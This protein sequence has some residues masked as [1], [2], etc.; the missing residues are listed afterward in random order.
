MKKIYNFLTI[1]FLLVF[2]VSCEKDIANDVFLNGVAPILNI[3]AASSDS[4]ALNYQNETDEAAYISWTNPNYIFASGPN[5]QD[6]VYKLEIDSFGKNFSGQFKKTV[7]F[8]NDL[9]VAYNVF[10]FNA[11]L[12]DLKLKI[13]TDGKISMRLISSING[14]SFTELT[15]AQK[16]FKVRP[17]APPPKVNPP[18]SGNLWV[19][20]DAFA[21]SW[22]N[23]LASPYDVSQKFTKISDTRYELLVSFAGGG[24]YKIIQEQ[25]VWGTQFHKVAGNFGNGTF[26]Q[27]DADPA[28][29]GAPAAGLYKIILDFQEGTYTVLAAN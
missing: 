24:G 20:G 3:E 28:F 13:N 21:S 4:I 26:E 1:L 10:Q 18:A 14:N 22:S 27:K 11:L 15:S 23:P 25:G 2:L 8:K 19:T 6:I 12:G 29:N 5:S 7:S 17:Y 16:D 9:N